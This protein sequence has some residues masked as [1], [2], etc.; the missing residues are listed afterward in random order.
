MIVEDK[1]LFNWAKKG[2]VEPLD[3]DCVNP[4][5]IDLR[6]SGRIKVAVGMRL[7]SS[8][9]WYDIGREVK[10]EG[11][12]L[13]PKMFYLMD[14]LEYLRVPDVWAGQLSLKSTMARLGVEGLDAG[15]FDPGFQGTATFEVMVVSPWPILMKPG[16]RM[17]QMIFHILRSK[18][19]KTYGETGRYQ[20]Q[21]EP[22]PAVKGRIQTNSSLKPDMKGLSGID[23]TIEM[24]KR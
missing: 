10:K 3:A 6:W 9:I 21:K 4:A 19:S 16:D 7:D 15:Y 2:G 22:Q 5:S 13:L 18:P 14:S 1:L 11:F 17:F 8:K 24:A 20:G 12:M 23:E